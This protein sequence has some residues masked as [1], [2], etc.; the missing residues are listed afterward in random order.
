MGRM[1]VPVVLNFPVVV[2]QLP[3]LLIRRREWLPQGMLLGAWRALT[4]PLAGLIF[5]WL[6][7][8]GID[9][10]LA[11]FRSTVRPRL[12]W[13]EVTW[14][15]ILLLVGAMT[16]VGI[17]TTTP[18]DRR[19]SD[20]MALLYGGLLWGVLAALTIT[21]RFRQWRNGKKQSSGLTLSE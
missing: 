9:A 15:S 12:N 6:A 2:A 19:D 13:M 21:A 3:Y 11:S 18:D 10:L 17:L 8:R 7:G 1:R 20:F 16:L 5:W 14:A 4:W